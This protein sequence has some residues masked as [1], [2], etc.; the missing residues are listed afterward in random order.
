MTAFE[1]VYDTNGDEDLAASLPRE[2]DL[3]DGMTDMDEIQNYISRQADCWCIG[4][5]IN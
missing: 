3:P 4:F 1:I 5:R 2:I